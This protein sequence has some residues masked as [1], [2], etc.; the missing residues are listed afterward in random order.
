VFTPGSKYLRSSSFKPESILDEGESALAMF[1]IG[2]TN[3]V[4]TDRRV[5]FLDALDSKIKEFID[6]E[7]VQE[8]VF[9]TSMGA[10]RVDARMKDGSTVKI[11]TLDQKFV[12]VAK[13][14]FAASLEGSGL[15]VL[16]ELSNPK[17]PD[18]DQDEASGENI[19]IRTNSQKAFPKWLIES[20]H[21]H[22][23]ETEDVLMV[24]TE[25]YV[26]HQ[27]ALVVF[28]DRC[29]I[30]KG[31]FWGGLMAGS[32][33]G[34]RAG[35]FYFTQITGVEYNSGM[36]TGVL[37]ILTPSYQGS[38]NK[39][40]WRGTNK[41]RNADSNDPWTLSNCLPLSKEGYKSAQALITE[42]K[43]L[44]SKSQRPT[45]SQTIVQGSDLASELKK[46]AEL[47][48]AGILSEEEFSSAKAKLING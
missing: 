26:N 44:I 12:E 42:L 9:G 23:S 11:G 5:L 8:F 22:K 19:Q 46:L 32:L 27:G 3:K 29:M 17:E 1:Q 48:D 6:L 33:G 36:L 35:T 41:S 38:A 13:R 14:F 18:N 20:I 7:K 31:G 16:E 10:P 37:E 40:Y 2:L 45:V 15:S 47:R 28:E 21:T 30:V 34:E 43:S 24:I 4:L 39:D 25:P